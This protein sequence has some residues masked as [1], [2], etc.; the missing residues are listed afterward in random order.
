M[1]YVVHFHCW[2]DACAPAMK[3][4][5]LYWTGLPLKEKFCGRSSSIVWFPRK[6]APYMVPPGLIGIESLL[7]PAGTSK[8]LFCARLGSVES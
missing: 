8:L 5:K 3:T 1:R 4:L 7:T 2:D 6:I